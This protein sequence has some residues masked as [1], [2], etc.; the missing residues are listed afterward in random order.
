[1]QRIEIIKYFFAHYDINQLLHKWLP[2]PKDQ[3]FVFDSKDDYFWGHTIQ[4]ILNFLIFLARDKS[5]RL[6][7]QVMAFGV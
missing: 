6:N 3:R 5:K 2:D 1:V 7:F 4:P